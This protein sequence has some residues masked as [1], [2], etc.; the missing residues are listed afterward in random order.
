MDVKRQVLSP[1][2][3]GAFRPREI[4]YQAP[5]KDVLFSMGLRQEPRYLRNARW[6]NRIK[7][8]GATRHD[9]RLAAEAF[10]QVHTRDPLRI[11]TPTGRV[12]QERVSPRLETAKAMAHLRQGLRRGGVAPEFLDRLPTPWTLGPDTRTLATLATTL[13]KTRDTTPLEAYFNRIGRR[14]VA[15]NRVLWG[16]LGLG[17]IGLGISQANLLPHRFSS[18]TANP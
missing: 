3:F 14:N 17:L 1:G 5:R 8:N 15:L 11:T 6:E 2:L 4:T 13:A 7:V 12:W 18:T 10:H 16:G 9:L